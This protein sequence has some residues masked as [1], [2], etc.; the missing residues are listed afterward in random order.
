MENTLNLP[1][2]SVGEKIYDKVP[3]ICRKFGDKVAIL[4]GKTALSKALPAL[5]EVLNNNAFTVTA[6]LPYGGIASMQA[7]EGLAHL[8]EVQQADM[9]FA[10]GGGRAIDTVKVVGDLLSKPVFSF[11]T[12]ASNCAPI[13]QLSILYHHDTKEFSRLYPLKTCPEHCF[14]NLSVILD[15]PYEYFWAGIGDA[16]SKQYETSFSVRNEKLNFRNRLGLQ[17]ALD[18]SPQLYKYGIDA[19]KDHRAGICSAA[20]AE[21]AV[22]IIINTGFVSIACDLNYSS[23]LAHALYYGATVL[24]QGEKHLHGAI[25]NYGTLVL[26]A[27]DKDW[28]N[29]YELLSFSKATKLPCSLADLDIYDPEE[30]K[31]MIRAAMQT[32]D[33]KL[34]PYPIDETKVLNTMQWLEEK[35]SSAS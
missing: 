3:D 4:G 21:T 7:A 26:L 14:I 8:P 27:M 6:V 34:T 33:L 12:L 35:N 10:V 5:Q 29:F 23:S 17:I 31:A 13:T 24:P 11:P 32:D 22:V 15:S 20:L 25:V 19:L 16:L 2:F 1:S 9:L 28:D 30:I 18:C